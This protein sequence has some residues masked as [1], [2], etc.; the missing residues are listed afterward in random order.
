MS[1]PTTVL[2]VRLRFG[3]FNTGESEIELSGRTAWALDRLIEAGARGCSPLSEPAGPRWAAYVH[4]L[5]GLGI[6]IATHHVPHGGNFPGC[7]GKYVLQSEIEI[8]PEGVVA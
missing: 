7:H 2:R 1:A 3:R 5:R 6:G 8:I 4:R